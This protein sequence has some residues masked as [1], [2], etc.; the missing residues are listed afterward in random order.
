MN[1]CDIIVP[2][3][4][5]YDF[6]IKCIES[7]L[8]NTKFN[9]NKLILIDD[10]SPDERVLPMLKEYEKKYEF[11]EVLENEKNLGFVGTVNKGM[12][13]S[14]S[15]VLLLN[16]DTEV[17]FDWLKR[18]S[19]CAYSEKMIGTVTPLS[20]NATHVSV[21]IGLQENDL[22]SNMSLDEYGKLVEMCAY[23]ENQQLPT[24]HGFCMFI[25]REVLDLIGY[26]DEETF[27]KGYGEENDF[28]FRCLDYG[29][30]NILCDNV[31]IYHKEKQ[32]FSEKREELI[33]VNLKK[34]HDRY[35][36]YSRRIELWCENFP[37]RKICEN[38]DYQIKLYNR[39]NILILIH[40][41]N[42]AENNLGGTT[43]HVYDLIRTM[44][45]KYNFHVLAPAD[46][47]YKLTSYFEDDV[48]CLKFPAIDS[49]NLFGF[50]NSQYRKMIE[51]IVEGFR[52]D[53]IHIHHM[54]GHFFD[55]MDVAKEK[56]IYSLI[57]LH[58]FYSLCPS[59]NMLFKMEK[60]CP[61]LRNKDCGE[62]LIY[63]TGIRNNVIDNW[64]DKWG[65]F[66]SNFDKVIVPSMNTK[67]EIGKT[68]KNLKID[69]IEH[70]IDLE[71]SNYISNIENSNTYNVAFVGVMTTHKGGK[72]LE[73]LIR[74][75]KGSNL[76]FHLFGTSEF[77]ELEKNKSNYTYHGRYK[78]EELPTLLAE[79]NINLVCNFSIW[80]ETYSYTLTEEIAS[81][82][83]VLSFNIGAVGDRI[84]E[85]KY[86]YIVDIDSSTDEIIEKINNIFTE[87]DI[88]N[89]T[90]K[91]IEKY[92]IKTTDEMCKEYIQ[93]YKK[94]TLINNTKEKS[95]ALKNIIDT[96]YKVYETVNSAETAWILN[97]LKWKIVSKIKVPEFVKKVA[98]KIVG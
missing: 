4:N 23:N 45:D 3:Y 42:D 81:G 69:V 1:K 6:V 24:A 17:T 11:I 56:N 73:E 89:K 88:Y 37:I 5:A 28:S 38:I 7:V 59:I 68:Y 87:K 15:D 52:I 90:I 35:P 14:K 74:K 58:D 72:I 83:P 26:F 43:L 62:C 51:D 63:K 78:R 21:P 64:H 60:Y 98:R 33:K 85:N 82:V 66:L 47:I 16:S 44:R 84:K 34:L 48:K 40:D 93:I 10:K 49:Y 71:K 50:Y 18:I 53:T 76:K 27:G 46:G 55:I 29:Y 77:K 39:K 67:K 96:N 79:N 57:T 12:K 94:Q 32:S 80:A 41:W 75:T 19:E 25:K 65:S 97:S 22:P 92:H 30:K 36:I 70:G 2:I 61:N 9:G 54:I 95:N 13:Y 91:S 86:G 20:N 8:K 31:I